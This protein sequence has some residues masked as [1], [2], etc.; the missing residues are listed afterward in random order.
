MLIFNVLTVSFPFSIES[1]ISVLFLRSIEMRKSEHNHFSSVSHLTVYEQVAD[2]LRSKIL[3]GE[4]S[5]GTKLMSIS[6]FSKAYGLSKDSVERGY[7]KLEAE[8][9]IKA[10]PCKGC[11]VLESTGR[12]DRAAF[13]TN[14]MYDY[15]VRLYKSI[16]QQIGKA[17]R[18]DFILYHDQAAQLEEWVRRNQGNFD[19]YIFGCDWSGQTT[20]KDL[21]PILAELPHDKIFV[22]GDN[23]RLISGYSGSLVD[24][25]YSILQELEANLA[26]LTKYKHIKMSSAD[27][28]VIPKDFFDGVSD[29]GKRYGLEVDLVNYANLRTLVPQCLYICS[30]DSELLSLLDRINKTN[31]II[32]EDIGILSFNDT[33]LKKKNGISIIEDDLNILSKEVSEILSNNRPAKSHLMPLTIKIRESC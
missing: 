15:N 6:K 7:N 30:G 12:Q 11:F 18:V 3:S 24:Y 10:V 20:Y 4:L 13:I 28:L 22:I 8:G 19:H 5:V 23:N 21:L 9:L 17:T 32:G 25:R 26:T 27:D 31:F 2:Y 16:C 1:N 14:A 29:F 33:L